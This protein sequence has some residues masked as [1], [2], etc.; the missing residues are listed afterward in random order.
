MKIDNRTAFDSR[1]LRIALDKIVAEL[2]RAPATVRL[3]SEFDRV[4]PG[5]VIPIHLEAGVVLIVL[6]P[7]PRVIV[8]AGD[9]IEIGRCIAGVVGFEDWSE[10]GRAAVVGSGLTILELLESSAPFALRR[11]GRAAE[12]RRAARSPKADRR[13]GEILAK[14]SELRSAP[15]SG[16]IRREIGRQARLLAFWN[17]AGGSAHGKKAPA[18]L[19]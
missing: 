17:A 13:V 8:F 16:K 14:L 12:A 10:R 7:G 19:G 6:P 3:V 4:P 15:T 5:K 1:P 9:L 11:A 18:I 2:G